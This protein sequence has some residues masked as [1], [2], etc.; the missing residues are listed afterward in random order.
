MRLFFTPQSRYKIICEN[1]LDM[2]LIKYLRVYKHLS[3]KNQE[4]LS[5]LTTYVP[6]Q[7][8]LFKNL[9]ALKV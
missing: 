8:L 7:K 3:S 1:Q 4:Q 6:T 5:N 2:K 9:A